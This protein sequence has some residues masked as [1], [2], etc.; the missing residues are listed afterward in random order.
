M[1]E[2]SVTKEMIDKAELKD[3]EMGTLNNSIRK[4]AGNLVGFIGEQVALSIM[5]GSWSNTYDYDLVT[6]EGK[7]V[8]VKTKQTTVPP[9]SYY[10][11]SVAKFNTSQKCDAYAF[12]R[13]K[14]TLDTA[15]FL[16]VMDKQEY[17]KKATP[18][19]KGDVDPSNNFTVRADCYNLK[20]E[21]LNLP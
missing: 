7:K 18:L 2:V 19:K 14:N 10:E 5:G 8:D 4:G 16:G 15:W 3:K 6:E 13:V 21:E 12:V 1:I 11:C 20:I 17:Y 9:R